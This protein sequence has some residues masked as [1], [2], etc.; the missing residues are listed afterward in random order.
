MHREEF[1][2]MK[3][4]AGRSPIWSQRCLGVSCVNVDRAQEIRCLG[5]VAV[6]GTGFEDSMAGGRGRATRG[7]EER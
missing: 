6:K 3:V 1:T 2:K 4:S 5:R 7:G